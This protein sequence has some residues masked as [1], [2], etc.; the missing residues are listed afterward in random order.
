M[1]YATDAC[2]EGSTYG[3][4]KMCMHHACACKCSDPAGWCRC[5]AQI[6]SQLTKL[7]GRQLQGHVPLPL[8]SPSA[9]I[10]LCPGPSKYTAF[11]AP[12]FVCPLYNALL[13]LRWCQCKLAVPAPVAYLRM[14]VCKHAV[15]LPV[16]SR[17]ATCRYQA[18]HKPEL[19]LGQL[20]RRLLVWPGPWLL[21]ARW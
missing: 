8:L 21:I 7:P 11:L 3:L 5:C 4:C 14:P 17:I 18:A 15:A 9:N 16:A 10:M 13:K 19:G 20:R 6:P 2:E 1:A 12:D